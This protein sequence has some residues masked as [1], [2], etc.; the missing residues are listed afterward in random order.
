MKTSEQRRE[1]QKK[2]RGLFP[3]Q[4]HD[5]KWAHE[6]ADVIQRQWQQT[7]DN[8]SKL[9]FPH[10]HV[11]VSW[12]SVHRGCA[13]VIESR[14]ITHT[15]TQTQNVTPETKCHPS[16]ADAN[17]HTWNS[18]VDSPG[19]PQHFIKAA[20]V[21]GNTIIKS[22]FCLFNYLNVFVPVLC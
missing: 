22:L 19:Y 17:K 8:V 18:G 6:Q 7:W 2:R 21:L 9:F 14:A 3:D 16:Y 10:P 11:S 1:R 4:R 20:G 13:P 12:L 5:R 15:P